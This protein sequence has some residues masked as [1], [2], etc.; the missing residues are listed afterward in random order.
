MTGLGGCL[1]PSIKD[2]METEGV[3]KFYLS[4]LNDRGRGHRHWAS[5]AVDEMTRGVM[6]LLFDAALR[7]I[8]AG[9]TLEFV[10]G[11]NDQGA[12]T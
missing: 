3:Q 10:K 5:D 7:R 2:I 4:Q 6:D 1:R 8:K 9:E 12:I 11:D